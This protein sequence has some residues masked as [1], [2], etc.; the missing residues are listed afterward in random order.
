MKEGEE[1]RLDGNIIKVAW[2]TNK[3]INKDKHA[4]AFWNVE[5]GCTFIPWSELERSPGSSIDFMKWSDGGL[6]DEDSIPDKY[7][8]VYE[9]QLEKQAAE[10]G[11]QLPTVSTDQ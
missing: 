3:G 8:A 4:K 9:K 1:Y 7:R 5:I 2:A 10:S 6:I 11:K